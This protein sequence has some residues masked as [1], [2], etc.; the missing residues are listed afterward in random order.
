MRGSIRWCWQFD[1]DPLC[2]D[3]KISLHIEVIDLVWHCHG[4]GAVLVEYGGGMFFLGR[5]DDLKPM[6]LA[7]RG[8]HLEV[9]KIETPD[10]LIV[11]RTES[12]PTIVSREIGN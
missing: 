4:L 1:I 11:L 6:P 3:E 10:A 2:H 9:V 7:K 8:D 12:V 5:L